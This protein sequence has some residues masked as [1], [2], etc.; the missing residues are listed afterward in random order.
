[1][2]E[3]NGAFLDRYCMQLFLIG[4]IY[5][6]ARQANHSLRLEVLQHSR[7]DL[8]RCAHVGSNSIMSN[9]QRIVLCQ[10]AFLQ[11]KRGKPFVNAFPHDLFDQLHDLGETRGHDLIDVI[12]NDEGLLHQLFEHFCRND[13]EFRILFRF[14]SIY[15]W[16]VRFTLHGKH[17]EPQ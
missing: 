14:N 11:Q 9:L 5:R 7:D 1:M 13:I 17:Q 3:R 12:C 8:P 4:Q 10:S 2:L 16:A 15:A 6:T